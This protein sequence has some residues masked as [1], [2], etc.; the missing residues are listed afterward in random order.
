MATQ[1]ATYCDRCGAVLDNNEM[2]PRL[3]T[4]GRWWC[5]LR[6]RFETEF[7]RTTF[8]LCQNC[9]KDLEHFMQTPPRSDDD[10]APDYYAGY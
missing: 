10:E 2:F 8:D 3:H 7:D 1:S 5:G 6:C 9:A 4:L